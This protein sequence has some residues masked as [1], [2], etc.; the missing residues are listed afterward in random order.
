MRIEYYGETVT[1][2]PSENPITGRPAFDLY[3]ERGRYCETVTERFVEERKVPLSGELH[4]DNARP[5]FECQ[6]TVKRYTVHSDSSI[7]DTFCF[8]CHATDTLAL[9]STTTEIYDVRQLSEWDR[10]RIA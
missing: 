10:R 4:S 8:G 3:D 2:R 7:V 9:E 5:C 1:A 6:G